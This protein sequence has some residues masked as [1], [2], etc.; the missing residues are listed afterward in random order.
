MIEKKTDKTAFVDVNKLFMAFELKQSLE[1]KLETIQK[2][3]QLQ[4][5]SLELDL[6]LFYNKINEKDKSSI[7]RF[8]LMRKNFLNAKQEF[9]AEKQK[10]ANEY[11]NQIYIQI[12]QYMKDFGKTEGYSFIFGAN[13][14]GNLMF[15]KEEKDVTEQAIKFI[16]AKYKGF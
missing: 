16:N 9:E 1:K 5:D 8:Q 4:L 13:G 10:L 14:N 12:S 6:K 7:E 11:D 15:A 2:Q 3:R